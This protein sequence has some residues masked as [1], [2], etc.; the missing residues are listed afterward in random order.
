[1]SQWYNYEFTDA[2][3]INNDSEHVSLTIK[4]TNQEHAK[5]EE[6]K[7]GFGMINT[8][9][10]L[11][12]TQESP[13]KAEQEMLV[14]NDSSARLHKDK[15]P[16]SQSESESPLK[17]INN[18]SSA[19]LTKDLTK[20]IPLVESPTKEE[21]ES[22]FSR[23]SFF[24]KKRP[25]IG[26]PIKIVDSVDKSHSDPI[27]KT[28]DEDF[29]V[30][31]KSDIT[32]PTDNPN[33]SIQ[34]IQPIQGEE[35]NELKDTIPAAVEEKKIAGLDKKMGFGN[36]LA[37]GFTLKKVE[38]PIVEEKQSPVSFI[39]SPLLKAS[40][41]NDSHLFFI[42]LNP[43][44][45]TTTFFENS[46]Q[47]YVTS[48]HCF[49]M[50]VNVKAI[51]RMQFVSQIK[52]FCSN[53]KLI[54]VEGIEESTIKANIKDEQI[55]LKCLEQLEIKSILSEYAP[56]L[57][58]SKMYHISTLG[59]PATSQSS[60]P[61]KEKSKIRASFTLKKKDAEMKSDS[62]ELLKNMVHDGKPSKQV[63]MQY[64][65]CFIASP[66]GY[67]LYIKRQ[68][69]S[70]QSVY[71]DAYRDYV[72]PLPVLLINIECRYAYTCYY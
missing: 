40:H 33:D 49:V 58:S 65:H 38:R 71:L 34:P 19:T 26:S 1:M 9:I 45:I 53:R 5:K 3:K 21:K 37:N 47:I 67:F 28:I 60:S 44:L 2:I 42:H 12:K 52:E 48:T 8:A 66:I 22:T 43:L 13:I 36:I 35:S 32:T 56:K 16:T 23:A 57:D 7:M 27:K 14:S 25:S 11:K 59:T 50:F 68:K 20:D 54:F 64:Q 62:K 39:K 70:S 51:Q 18:S 31:D 63:L 41:S 72:I 30:I 55:V 15:R 10:P 4:D 24:K 29:Q 6:K 69:T 61:V 17:D 46:S